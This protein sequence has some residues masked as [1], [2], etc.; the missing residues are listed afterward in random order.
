MVGFPLIIIKRNMRNLFP[1]I[2][3]RIPVIPTVFSPD[4]WQPCLLVRAVGSTGYFDFNKR[5]NIEGF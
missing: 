2:L 4:T 5:I 1:T 3:K